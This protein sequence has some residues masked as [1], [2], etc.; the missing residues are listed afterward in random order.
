MKKIDLFDPVCKVYNLD[1]RSIDLP[2]T[3]AGLMGCVLAPG[4]SSEAHS[5][6]EDEVFVF[7]SGAG[8]VS[9][10][11]GVLDV[12]AG[13]AVQFARHE[14]HVITN[15][16]ATQPL[17][18][19][20]IYW[21]GP[22]A[23]SAAPGSQR[24]ALVFSTPPTPN[25]D[26]HLGHLS[27]PYLAADVLRRTLA[28]QGIDVHHATGRDDHQTY[29]V[30]CAAR[31]GRPPHDVAT[32]YAEAIQATWKSCGIEVD[33]FVSPDSAGDYSQFVRDGL[34]RLLA[35]GLLCEKEAP[36]AFDDHGMYLHEAHIKGRC[37]HCGQSSDGNACEAC[38]RPNA[39]VDLLQAV[40]ART[41]ATPT[42]AP[43]RRL[44]F[45]LSALSQ[46]LAQYVRSASMPA[47]VASL[48]LQMI[49]DGLPDIC[50]SHPGD[51]G[52]RHDIAGYEAQVVY[53]WFEMAFGY[54]W[55]AATVPHAVGA[56][57]FERAASVYSHGTDIIHCYG[58]DNT[59]YHTLLFPAVYL[60]LGLRPPQ[61]HVVN[62]LLD[63]EGSK[64]STSRRHLIWGQELLQELPRDY[65]RF[66]LLLCRPE[67]S[68]TN[69]VVH[70]VC[71]HLNAL[72]PGHL[73]A[74]LRGLMDT[75]ARY[76][77]SVPQPGAWL[78]D[79]R[80]FHTWLTHQMASH[81]Q[82]SQAGTFSPR[83]L[84]Q[85]V[86]RV[87]EE[88]RRFQDSQAHLFQSAGTA[89][90]NHARTAA[91]LSALAAKF[92]AHA[93]GPLM[94]RLAGD[95]VMMLGLEGRGDWREEVEQFFTSPHRVH[96][97]LMPQLPVVEEALAD[98]LTQTYRSRVAPRAQGPAHA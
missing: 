3:T 38:G 8:Q 90:S 53:V 97:E 73:Q 67:G 79:Q 15:T 44:Y 54:L 59:Y 92:V 35:L 36:A 68:R 96:A 5:H 63:L 91:A 80:V 64:F 39:C 30:T 23:A 10:G 1:C 62:E 50:I 22:A 20:S 43:S 84:A 16:S 71:S 21:P 49:E 57:R 85:T 75:L 6:L 25:G 93:L 78:A 89:L 98:K 32:H 48:S 51:W 86:A 52:I 40:V 24:P 41:G 58:F 94:P 95:L 55:A 26:L 4:Q 19:H 11:Q 88:S 33:T 70:E 47:H 60:A 76:D 87:I 56:N 17:R 37:P 12:Q 83:H 13:D 66:A 61:T 69:F 18:F 14:N 31:E 7:V 27:G 77:N 81:R 42:L 29:V 82:A 34:R 45:R 74:W 28:D 2:G 65:A 72:F 46:P 9:C